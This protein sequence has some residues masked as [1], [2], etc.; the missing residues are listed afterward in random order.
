MSV[1]LNPVR[2]ARNRVGRLKSPPQSWAAGRFHL[3]RAGKPRGTRVPTLT[4]YLCK[5]THAGLF[6]TIVHAL[7]SSGASPDEAVR[8]VV[9]GVRAMGGEGKTVLLT[10]LAWDPRVLGRFP[11]EAGADGQRTGGVV[12]IDVG[13]DVDSAWALLSQLKD[14]L[15][16][17]VRDDK[18]DNDD[19]AKEV[20]AYLA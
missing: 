18:A 7:I 11:S 8:I 5:A 19:Q 3:Y 1:P 4:R 14:A 9:H 2:V 17:Q 6:E 20:A 13:R 10:R 15:G 12:W 16:I